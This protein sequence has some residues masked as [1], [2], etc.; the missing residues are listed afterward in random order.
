MQQHFQT[1]S[2]VG[3][4][5]LVVNTGAGKISI[6][7]KKKVFYAYSLHSDLMMTMN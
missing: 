6:D 1:L 5:L 3:G 2:I 7:E 4:L